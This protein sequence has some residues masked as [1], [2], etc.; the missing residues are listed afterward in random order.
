MNNTITSCSSPLE[1]SSTYKW[2]FGLVMVAV[3]A[4]GWKYPLLGFIV[5]AAMSAGII[6][7]FVKGRWVCGNAC[8][9]GSFLDSWFSLVSGD[10]EIPHILKNTKLRLTI[11]SA[12]MGFMVFRLAQNPSSV[13]HWGI[14]FWQMCAVTTIAAI[15]LGIRYSARSWCSLCPIGTIAGAAGKGKHPLQ[16]SASCKLCH[17][18]ENNCPMQLE[19][20]RYRL[21]GQSE[22]SD[23]I[24]CSECIS[25]CPHKDVLSWPTKAAA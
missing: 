19:I 17:L 4:L 12:L 25:V 16:V 1:K 15:G 5:P 23:C 20:A 9:R 24:K 22:E 13:D 8:P 18:C 3:V 10:R 2:L 21:T 7:G 6:G 11:L 14:V